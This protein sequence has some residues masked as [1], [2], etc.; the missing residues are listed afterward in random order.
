MY[1]HFLI[2]CGFIY[3]YFYISL[4]KKKRKFGNFL[5]NN[6]YGRTVTTANSEEKTWE[7]AMSQWEQVMVN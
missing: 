1:W 6:F 2:S 7:A 4:N 3:L 5:T